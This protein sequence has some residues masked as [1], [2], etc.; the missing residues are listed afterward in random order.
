MRAFGLGLLPCA[1]LSC[2]LAICGAYAPSPV[3]LADGPPS[4]ENLAARAALLR[5]RLPE[6][7]SV[8]EASP[9]LLVSEEPASDAERRGAAIRRFASQLRGLFFTRD[10]PHLIDVWVF[11]DATSYRGDVSA[12]LGDYPRT[13]HGY[14]APRRHAIVVNLTSGERTLFHELVHPTSTPTSPAA[15]AGSTRAWPRSSSRP[16]IAGAS[17]SAAPTSACRASSARSPAAASH[18]SPRSR[19]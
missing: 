8:V 1:V 10:P 4:D 7:F 16:R 12:Y 15:P 14:Y 17:S 19:S 11:A 6:T 9:L 3:P 5:A 13:L 2:L 18:H